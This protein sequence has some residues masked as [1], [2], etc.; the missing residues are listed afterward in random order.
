[1]RQRRAPIAILVVP[2]FPAVLGP[3]HSNREYMKER[4]FLSEDLS[5]AQAI[6]RV[7]P[8]SD[9][10]ANPAHL[11]EDGGDAA[12]F[13]L[14]VGDHVGNRVDQR[15]VGESLGE[16]AEVAAGLGLQ[17]LGEEVEPA[18]RLEQALAELPRP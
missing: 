6:V 9:P 7:E 8:L 10:L 1:M 4:G 11:A 16:V 18:G 17:L 3:R 2:T 12:V 15:Q 13:A 14:L 5:S